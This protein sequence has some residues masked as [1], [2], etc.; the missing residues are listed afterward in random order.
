VVPGSLIGWLR[1]LLLMRDCLRLLVSACVCSYNVQIARSFH[2]NNHE[3]GQSAIFTVWLP[4]SDTSVETGGLAVLKGSSSLPG[5]QRCR[6]TYGDV[7]VSHTDISDSGPLTDVGPKT[8]C[9][10][11]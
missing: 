5:F 9:H 2:S 10:C 11:L 7:D 6:E 4:W 1:L 8:L 3:S